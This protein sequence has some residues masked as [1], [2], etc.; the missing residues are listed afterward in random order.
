[1]LMQ[2]ALKLFILQIANKITIYK[3]SKKK[4]IQFRIERSAEEEE[5]E[6]DLGTNKKKTLQNHSSYVVSSF[7][8]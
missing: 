5:E 1:M 2:V 7:S 3:I 6:I 4:W 8:V